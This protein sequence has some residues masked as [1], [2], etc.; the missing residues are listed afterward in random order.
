MNDE[1]FK[2]KKMLDETD[3]LWHQYLTAFYADEKR[4]AAE[5]YRDAL[6]EASARLIT[7][8]AP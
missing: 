8:L 5:A 2:A 1:L 3:A 4:E 6:R 7:A